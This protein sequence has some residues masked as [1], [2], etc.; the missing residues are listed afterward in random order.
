MIRQRSFA[1]LL[2]LA[3]AAL[4]GL[5]MSV[6]LRWALQPLADNMSAT[7]F[8]ADFARGGIVVIAL[9]PVP[10]ALIV[11]RTLVRRFWQIPVRPRSGRV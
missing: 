10:F 3:A 2:L 5:A 4:V 7:G 9:L 8:W 1:Y 11:G 6:L